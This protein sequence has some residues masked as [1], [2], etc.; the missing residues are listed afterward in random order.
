MTMK[1]LLCSFVAA[2]VTCTAAVSHATFGPE[3]DVA[4]TSLPSVGTQFPVVAYYNNII[5]VAFEGYAP[6][7]I[8][9]VYY[10]RST[11]NG[12]SFSVPI[13]I[14]NN[15]SAAVQAVRPQIAASALGV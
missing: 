6:G 3:R 13:N 1:K 2:L 7:N 9:D 4:G 12:A 14:S 15:G 10:V 5:H 11:D 8:V